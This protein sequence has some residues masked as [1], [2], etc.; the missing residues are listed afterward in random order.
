MALL[1]RQLR[2]FLDD[3]AWLESRRIMEIVH[4]IETGA[5]A[6]RDEQPAGTFMEIDAMAADMELPL[7]RPLYSPPFKSDHRVSVIAGG[8]RGSRRRCS[9]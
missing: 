8:R 9:L 4:Q 7:E 1:S 2:R 6:V 3:R 5:L